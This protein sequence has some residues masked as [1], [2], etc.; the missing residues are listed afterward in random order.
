MS[1]SRPLSLLVLILAL[2]SSAACR[3]TTD[4]EIRRERQL[5]LIQFS[6]DPLVIQHPETVA[7]ASTFEVT[8]R[9]Y[10]NGC[11]DQGDTE[12]SLVGAMATVRPYDIFVTHLPPNYACTDDLRLYTHRA[13]LHFEQPG[14]ATITIQGRA[15]PGDSTIVVQ[16]VVHVR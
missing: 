13:E 14:P 9:T 2:G 15:R 11:V 5:G 7:V 8:V 10:G 6:H 12:V 3:W 16:R 4:T 1:R